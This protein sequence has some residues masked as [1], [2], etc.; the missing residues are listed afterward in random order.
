MYIFVQLVTALFGSLGFALLFK[1]RNQHLLVAS[2][3]GLF[4]WGIYLLGVSL[5][6]NVFHS[7]LLASAFA[8]LYSEVFARIKKAPAVLFFIPTV[9]PL[10]PGSNLYYTMQGLATK[11]Y[12]F[13]KTNAILTLEYALGIAIGISIMWVI[14]SM[15]KKLK[16]GM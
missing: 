4:C 1:V 13:A 15:H 8:A 3:G 9:I 6:L 7:C 14:L 11:D 2:I 16:N 5:N 10:V 12:V